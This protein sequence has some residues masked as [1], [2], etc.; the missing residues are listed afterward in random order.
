MPDLTYDPTLAGQN[1]Q[2]AQLEI[3]FLATTSSTVYEVVP[4][5]SMLDGY[6]PAPTVARTPLFT[7]PT[8]TVARDQV[9]QRQGEGAQAFQ[10]VA[11]LNNATVNKMLVKARPGGALGGQILARYTDG[12]GNAVQGQA[13]LV[14][15]GEEG[16]D[17]A[18]NTIY[19]WRIEW[20]TSTITAAVVVP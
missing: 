4:G 18:A 8:G 7:G 3:N 9:S 15:T 20:M 10:S 12:N 14:Y 2:K 16:T 6:K 13:M 17:V 19:G 1:R 11:P 5:L